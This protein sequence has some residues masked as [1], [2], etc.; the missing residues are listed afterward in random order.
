MYVI[1]FSAFY[2]DSAVALSKDNS[3]IFAAQEERF[4][5]IKGDSSFPTNSFY[6]SLDSL[7]NDYKKYHQKSFSSAKIPLSVVYYENFYIKALRSLFIILQKPSLP[8]LVKLVN[9]FITK[10]PIRIRRIVLSTIRSYK[11]SNSNLD[12]SFLV[13]FKCSNHHLSHALSAHGV[14]GFDHSIGLVIDGVG[15]IDTISLWYFGGWRV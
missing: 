14:S 4:S 3:V 15:E 13:S 9:M 5:R 2:H 12:I 8:G 6:K 10:N 7:V 1:G 11:E